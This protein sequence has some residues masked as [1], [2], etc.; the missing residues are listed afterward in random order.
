MVVSSLWTVEDQSTS[1]LMEKFY[2]LHLEDGLEPA[3]A[4]R[5]AQFWLRNVKLKDM[6]DYYET[7]LRMTPSDAMTVLMKLKQRKPKLQPDDTP[8][9]HP[10]YWAAFKA[11]GL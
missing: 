1:L 3:Q 6:V 10:F 11:D 8:Y 2:K 9:S 7:Y 4:L 5:K